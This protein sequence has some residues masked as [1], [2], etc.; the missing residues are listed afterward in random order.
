MLS[1]SCPSRIPRA[2]SSCG[3]HLMA[4]RVGGHAEA[5]TEVAHLPPRMQDTFEIVVTPDPSRSSARDGRADPEAARPARLPGSDRHVSGISL[6]SPPGEERQ[7]GPSRTSSAV[8]GDHTLSAA[9][10][11]RDP[12]RRAVS[13]L[14]PTASATTSAQGSAI[15][16]GFLPPSSRLLERRANRRST[17]GTSTNEVFLSHR[18]YGFRRADPAGGRQPAAAS[19]VPACCGTSGTRHRAAC[20]L[21]MPS[22]LHRRGDRRE[23]GGAR[24]DARHRRQ[25]RE[26]SRLSLSLTPK[27]SP[28]DDASTLLV[29][30]RM[31][32]ACRL[33][34]RLL[35]I[36][37][38][39]R[40]TWERR[41]PLPRASGS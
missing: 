40:E 23:V 19:R 16:R 3:Q 4:G 24:R 39:Y 26:L 11:R 18:S 34:L 22:P 2:M 37:F 31:F 20:A 36:C 1:P 38:G 41:Y 12:S 9:A 5:W 30:P 17:W 13:S 25:R 6:R 28:I 15:R 35:K 7:A 27:A 14:C 10:S 8:G 32:E 29:I 21:Q 33:V